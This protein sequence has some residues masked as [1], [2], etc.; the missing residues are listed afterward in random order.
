MG[1]YMSLF[2]FMGSNGS[3]SVLV[4]PYSSLRIFMG[5]NKSLCVPMGLYGFL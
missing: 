2:V 4:V 3:L 1:P 5:P